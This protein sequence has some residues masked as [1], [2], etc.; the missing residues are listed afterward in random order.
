MSYDLFNLSP[1]NRHLD[2]FQSFAAANH[3]AMDISEC[4]KML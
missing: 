4:G 1:I 3:D 2:C